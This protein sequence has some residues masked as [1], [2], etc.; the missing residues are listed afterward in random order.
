MK[1]ASAA[2]LTPPWLGRWW[3]HCLLASVVVGSLAL[4]YL[5][6]PTPIVQPV[7]YHDFADRRAILGV[8][9][10]VDVAT[11]LPFLVVGLAGM[12]CCLRRTFDGARSGWLAFFA[13]V[14][15][16]SAGSAGYHWS[17]HNGTLL[18]D[19][20]P[21]TVAFMALCAALVGERVNDRAGKL[22]LVPALVVGC[23][24]VL[25][26]RWCGDL[27]PY[28]WVQFMP[29]L[30][31]PVLMVLFRSRYT[32]QGYLLAGLG[33]YVLAK[34]AEVSDHSVFAISGGRVGGHAGKH[35][36]AALACAA[37]WVMLRT[38]RR[39]APQELLFNRPGI[40]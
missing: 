25:F 15:L 2:S 37:L 29:L 35:L 11:N 33:F 39:A 20:L 13:G 12:G 5:L 19:R 23:L 6:F 32:R 38:R 28:A 18:W 3:R 40:R 21:I 36:L 30:A 22:L 27:R 7:G 31:L 8:P 34:L 9:N 4:L 1:A 16:A 10:F 24:S 14:T 26:W 17:P